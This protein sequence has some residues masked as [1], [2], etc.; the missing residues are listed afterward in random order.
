MKVKSPDIDQLT[1]EFQFTTSRSGGPGGQSVNKVNTRVTLRRNVVNAESISE[2]QR[3][4]ILTKLKKLINKEGE[5]VLST[6]GSRSQHRN[7]Q[8]SIDKLAKYLLEAFKTAKPR[9]ATKPTKGSIKRRLENKKKQG[10]KKTL[11][12]GIE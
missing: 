2:E 9:K 4:V 10:I 1:T 7:K 11:R 8:E 5:V 3:Q 12:G 6:H